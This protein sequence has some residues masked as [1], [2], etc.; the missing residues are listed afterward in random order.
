[1]G[2]IKCKKCGC[3]MSAMSEACPLCGTPTQEVETAVSAEPVKKTKSPKKEKAQSTQPVVEVEQKE[4]NQPMTGDYTM[5]PD[6]KISDSLIN[7]LEDHVNALHRNPQYSCMLMADSENGEIANHIVGE[8]YLIGT[9]ETLTNRA[10]LNFFI[11]VKTEEEKSRFKSLDN[12]RL[13]KEGYGD[14]YLIECGEDA[15]KCA[16]L[17]SEIV[18]KVWGVNDEIEFDDFGDKLT[19]EN[20]MLYLNDDKGVW[21]RLSQITKTY[22]GEAKVNKYPQF[23]LVA[24][25]RLLKGSLPSYLDSG[26]ALSKTHKTFKKMKKEFEAIIELAL[27]NLEV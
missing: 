15:E 7:I 6:V 11:T 24:S 4:V 9:T 20:V 3:E 16:Y 27:K 13:Y 18:Q 21:D 22:N 25:E 17:F 10:N 12:S 1:M 8:D 14:S 26:G 2:K 5:L 23:E 19:F